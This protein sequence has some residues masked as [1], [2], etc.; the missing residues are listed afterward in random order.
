MPIV[1][2]ALAIRQLAIGEELCVEARDPAFVPDVRAWSRMTGN[3][4]TNV[5]DGEVKRVVVRRT[6]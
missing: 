6:V 4:L 5:E 2:I 3:E 1:Q